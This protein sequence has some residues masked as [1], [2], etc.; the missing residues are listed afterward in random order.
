[1][2]AA[3]LDTSFLVAIALGEPGRQSLRT[4]L[5]RYD[6]LLSAE[7]LAAEFLAVAKREELPDQEVEK[8]FGAIRWVFPDRSVRPEIDDVLSVGYLRGADLWHLAC[9]RY[10][11]PDP[12]DLPFLSRDARQREVAVG[13]GFPTP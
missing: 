8:A 7:L 2:K 9:A 5:R 10:L 6:T 4:I 13:L 1:M 3:Y 12:K 11:A